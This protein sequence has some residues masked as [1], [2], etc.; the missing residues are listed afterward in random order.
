MAQAAVV[1]ALALLLWRLFV[2]SQK[3][4]HCAD[5]S[6]QARGTTASG[7]ATYKHVAVQSCSCVTLRSGGYDVQSVLHL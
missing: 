5:A 3:F 7:F 2:L 4:S 6:C 1:E